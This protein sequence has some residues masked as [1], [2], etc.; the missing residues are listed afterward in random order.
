MTDNKKSTDP[1]LSAAAQ[2]ELREHEAKE[3]ISDHEDAQ[4]AFHENRERLS[5]NDPP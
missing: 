2:K 4:T 1:G 3:A 5:P